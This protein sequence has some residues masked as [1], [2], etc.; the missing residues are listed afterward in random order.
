M[1]KY[2][3]TI[4]IGTILSTTVSPSNIKSDFKLDTILLEN[5]TV[6]NN[7]LELEDDCDIIG[8]TG[9]ILVLD[10]RGNV[11]R[12]HNFV[13]ETATS[14]RDCLALYDLAVMS[15]SLTLQQG[16]TTGGTVEWK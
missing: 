3:Y 5:E 9:N 10:S 14:F 6:L 15:V 11:I 16:E 12:R 4:L 13:G 7:L 8:C 1:K 2:I